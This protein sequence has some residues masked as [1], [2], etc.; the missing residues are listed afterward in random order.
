MLFW[1]KSLLVDLQCAGYFVTNVPF[2]PPWPFIYHQVQQQNFEQ[3]Y[4]YIIS[5]FITQQQVWDHL[6]GWKGAREAGRHGAGQHVN[7]SPDMYMYSTVQYS[8]V[9]YMYCTVFFV[10]ATITSGAFLAAL[11]IFYQQVNLLIVVQCV[12]STVSVYL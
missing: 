3:M 7:L 6:C 12:Y 10:F 8:T 11:F 4:Y 1:P 5:F 9:Q 2:S